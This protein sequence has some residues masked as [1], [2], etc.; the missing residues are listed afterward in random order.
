MRSEEP[1]NEKLDIE[2]TFLMKKL[3]KMFGN[4]GLSI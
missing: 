2:I 3:T 1:F 4:V